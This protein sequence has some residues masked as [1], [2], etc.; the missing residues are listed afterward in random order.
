M[1]EELGVADPGTRLADRR[2]TDLWALVT[3][4]DGT[5]GIPPG[6]PEVNIEHADRVLAALKASEAGDDGPMIELGL[7]P[8]RDE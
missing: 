1:L 4:P 2:W 7:F 8:A 3:N 5:R 6:W